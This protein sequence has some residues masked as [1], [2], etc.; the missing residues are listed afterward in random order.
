M[1]FPAKTIATV[2]AAVPLLMGTM[3]G[4]QAYT[5]PSPAPPAAPRCGNP[6]FQSCRIDVPVGGGAPPVPRHFC[7]HVP[8][9]PPSQEFPVIFAFHGNSGDGG[10][11]V[12]TWDKHTEQGMVLVAPSALPTGPGCRP[13]WRTIDRDFPDWSDFTTVDPCAPNA[14]R[15]HDLA[16]IDAISQ[17]LIAQGIAPQGFYAAGFSNGASFV[18]QL[19]ITER[20]AAAFDGF[21][22][23]SASIS[24]VMQAAQAAAAGAGPLQPNH[25]IRKPILLVRGTNEKGFVP[26]DNVVDSVDNV[27][28]PNAICPPVASALDV[29]ACYNDHATFPGLGQNNIISTAKATVDWYVAHNHSVERGIESLYPDLGH[30]SS[31]AD[32]ED[33]TIAVR[34]D[35][36]SRPGDRGLGGGGADHDHRRL[37]SM[38]GPER[39]RP[40]VRA[41]ELRRRHDRGGPAV[42]A[43]ECR[44]AGALAVA[45]R[46]D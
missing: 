15:G 28:V 35:F 6:E 9:A 38:V 34:Q 19:F 18:H 43:G 36:P 17:D 29:V 8:A 11:M 30:G 41:R 21:A 1:T 23:I 14:P 40:A 24:P 46:H 22:A 39:Q 2:A 25:D 20:F 7:I 45:R 26:W 13:S 44:S 12:T 37:P 33:A 27:L 31:F 32:H 4:A 3:H 10:V 42:L 5:C 16:L